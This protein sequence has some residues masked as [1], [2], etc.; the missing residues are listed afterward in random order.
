MSFPLFVHV[1]SFHN[2]C[3]QK[4]EQPNS[5]I[6]PLAYQ[7]R[8]IIPF[9]PNEWCLWK[10]YRTQRD[11]FNDRN[12]EITTT[13][14][15]RRPSVLFY[16]LCPTPLCSCGTGIG[17]HSRWAFTDWKR[18]R[19]SL[20]F[21]L[22]RPLSWTVLLS[23]VFVVAWCVYSQEIQKTSRESFEAIRVCLRF[24]LYVHNRNVKFSSLLLWRG[25]WSHPPYN[26]IIWPPAL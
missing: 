8:W 16:T 26:K 14:Y 6:F 15:I 4:P 12:N 22:K 2:S 17:Y 18:E 13:G 7:V 10:K 20:G 23:R 11:Y 3:S 24:F 21:T 25:L 9:V 1:A 19:T 5:L